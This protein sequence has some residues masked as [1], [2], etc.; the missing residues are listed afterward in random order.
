MG[1]LITKLGIDWKL[2]LANTLTFFIVLWLLR[3]FAFRPIMAVLDRRQKTIG[4]GLDAAKKS[5]DELAAIQ[6]DKTQVLKA[7]KTEAL[8]IVTVAK[9]QG[10]AARQK[11]AAEAQ[12]EVAA[13]LARTKLQLDRERQAMVNQAKTELADVVVM[14]TEKVLASTLDAK[15]KTTLADEAVAALREVQP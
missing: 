3:K 12:A 15:A 8:A 4:D 1:E 13:I 7:A 5:Q 11:L 2:L 14:A 6:R 9:K 10:E